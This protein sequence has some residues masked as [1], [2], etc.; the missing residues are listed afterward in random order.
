[1]VIDRS[2]RV[3]FVATMPVGLQ[4]S[5]TLGLLPISA[6]A[7]AGIWVLGGVWMAAV[8]A[9]IIL[10]GTPQARPWRLLER[11]FLGAG[12]LGF[13]GAGI[14]GWTDRL[15]VPGWLAGKLAA[16]GAMC[17]FALLLDRSFAPVLGAF[18]DIVAQGSTPPRE[19]VLRRHMYH[20][21]GWVLA[22]YAA[23]LVS[24]FLGT[25]RP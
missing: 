11:V 9:G 21:Y 5:R 8:V 24:G 12:L 17:L 10:N 1:M 23:I 3:C 18:S 19:A 6:A 15:A 16:F 25:V 2:P 7:M 13:T 14:A 20:T 4:I 22:I